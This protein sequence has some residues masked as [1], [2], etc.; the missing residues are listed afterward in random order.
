MTPIQSL[1]SIQGYVSLD[2]CCTAVLNYWA[3]D[4]SLYRCSRL[5]GHERKEAG[6]L[7]GARRPTTVATNIAVAVAVAIAIA[8]PLLHN[9]MYL[10]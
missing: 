10:L 1:P 9:I 6:R 2:R 7:D 8:L 5:D 3:I 4:A